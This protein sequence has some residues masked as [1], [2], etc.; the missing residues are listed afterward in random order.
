M[1]DIE[2]D[3]LEQLLKQA[4]PRPVPAPGDEATARAAVREE[5][6]QVTSARRS[7]RRVVQY[8]VAATVLLGVF[9][10]LNVLRTPPVDI[11]RVASIEKS[12]GSVFVLGDQAEL[13]EVND[14]MQVFSGQTIVTRDDAGLALAW[15]NGGSLRVG[16]NTRIDF[17]D[18]ESVFLVAGRA[19]FDSMPEAV[20]AD[21][22]AFT[23]RT[24][25]GDVYHVGTQYMGEIVDDTLIVSVREGEVFVDGKFH[26][27]RISSG[28]R[29]SMAGR[30]QP[31]VANVS[32]SG[33]AWEWVHNAMP[34]RNFD[35]KT[36]YEFV[37]WI[38]REMGLEFE[39]TE[40]AE[41]TAQNAFLSGTI[42][43]EPAK[44]L[45]A[46]L[47]SADLDWRIDEGVI[48]ITD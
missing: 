12:I 33:E 11:V 20:V 37:V 44:A 40:S 43:T 32:R 14:E 4:A 48:Y 47:A 1:S 10:V 42:R 6:R 41:A 17:V 39:F 5:W 24:E 23:L 38:S 16:A 36:A 46:W 3:S 2:R 22:T 29:V 19:Y 34:P 15:G 30:Q 25:L 35:G 7:R 28:Y 8:A 31:S 27:S 21:T 45:R 9:G 18:E 13:L 26:E